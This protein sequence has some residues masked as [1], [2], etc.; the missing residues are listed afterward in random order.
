MP[1]R[2]HD[3]LPKSHR[4]IPG[5]TTPSVNQQR[6]MSRRER[7]AQR[8]RQLYWGLGIAGALVVL[9]LGIAA[10]NEYWI[11]PRHVL[12]TVNGV[13][14]QRRDYWKYYAVDLA[15]QANQYASIAQSPFVDET[16]RQQ[17]I[18]LAQ[19]AS[20]K[21]D[22]VW[23][24]TSVDDPTLQRMIDDQVY[25]QSTDEFG[26]TITDEDVENFVQQKFGPAEAPVFT[27]TPTQTLIPERAEWAT[28]TAVAL[29]QGGTVAPPEAASPIASP[30]N[31]GSPA[32]TPV[33]NVS[34]ESSPVS[35]ISR[36]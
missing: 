16:Q 3:T 21:I 26:V 11:K 22:D 15:D 10:L 30:D 36:L 7:E 17:Y 5:Q 28:Q 25:L 24:T 8:R 19:E 12:A 27:P 4:R 2:R 14:I 34:S 29:E 33:D 1:Q 20:A 35:D 31:A 6:R 32:A 23:G 13:D 18:T 9:V